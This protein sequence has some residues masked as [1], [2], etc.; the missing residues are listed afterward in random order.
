MLKTTTPVCLNFWLRLIKIR[1]LLRNENLI[2][3]QKSEFTSVVKRAAGN[4]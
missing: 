4:D 1:Y 3:E 2:V